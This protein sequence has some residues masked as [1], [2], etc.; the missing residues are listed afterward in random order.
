MK[1][2]NCGAEL[3]EHA[4]VCPHCGPDIKEE[5][6]Y[7]LLSDFDDYSRTNK[8]KKT[9][10][11]DRQQMRRNKRNKTAFIIF[12][13]VI[14][15]ASAIGSYI[16]FSMQNANKPQ[17]EVEMTSG[18][19]II[20]K[21]MEI[22][23]A[24]FTDSSAIEFIQGV[25]LYQSNQDDSS[26]PDGEA[27]STDYDYTKSVDN[28]FRAVFFDTDK[29]DLKS[30]SE[31][32]YVFEIKVSFYDDENIYTYYQPVSFSKDNK[33]DISDIIF[34]HSLVTEKQK[35]PKPTTEKETTTKPITTEKYIDTLFI[36]DSYW[37]SAPVKDGDKLYITAYQFKQGGNCIA[38]QYMKD[39]DK[40]WEVTTS[41]IMYKINGNKLIISDSDSN[42]EDV[43]I[44]NPADHSITL[45][46][47][48][49]SE[50]MQLQQRQYN[51][52]KNAED[53]FGI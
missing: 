27:I 13:V 23:Y 34:D 32:K 41:T 2:K 22:I 8:S 37:Y 1:C 43:Y 53:F 47:D 50:P 42:A 30:D 51:S 31:Q 24:S 7:V 29:L 52:I 17:P 14:L 11:I 5:K 49:Q 6:D 4:K 38:T 48:S 16:F 44:L 21:N 45:E 19:G 10:S 33:S 39:G 28:S 36:Y 12:T 25:S 35:L 3:P 26:K 18:Y 40:K 9:E 15:L 20:D 46:D